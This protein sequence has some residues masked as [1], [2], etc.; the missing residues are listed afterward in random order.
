MFGSEKSAEDITTAI[1]VFANHIGIDINK[2]EGLMYI[3]NESLKDLP[4]GWEL[5]VG[6]EGM[7]N[8]GIPYFFNTETEE[9]Y[10]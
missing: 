9:R 2:D 6:A 7:D 3:A 4:D 8:A 5:G 10:V 1:L